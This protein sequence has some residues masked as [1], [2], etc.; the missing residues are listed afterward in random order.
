MQ[1]GSPSDS[2]SD[3]PSDTNLPLSLKLLTNLIS[4]EAS[5]FVKHI[6]TAWATG[7]H[8]I[9]QRMVAESYASVKTLVFHVGQRIL[10]L[11]NL[12][13]IGWG[14]G[15]RIGCENVRVDGP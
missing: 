2:L 3:F 10:S 15:P 8:K 4:R 11:S 9:G 7:R 14:I 6:L 5:N 13:E 1:I 12:H